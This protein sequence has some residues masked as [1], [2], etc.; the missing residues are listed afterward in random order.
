MGSIFGVGQSLGCDSVRVVKTKI[1]HR[2]ENE[3]LMTESLS[4]RTLLSGIGVA[5]F[6]HLRPCIGSHQPRIGATDGEVPVSG[7]AVVSLAPFDRMMTEFVDRHAIPGASLAISRNGAVIYARG[8]GLADKESGRI[9]QPDSLFRIA[10][11]SKPLTAIA[12]L[13]L[14]S[15]KSVPLTTPAFDIL[16]A[17][18]WLSQGSDDRLRRITI[19]DL[20]RHTAGWDRNLSFDPITRPIEAVRTTN[21]KLPASPEDI[22]RYALT[23]PIDFDPGTRFAYSNVGY[24]LLGRLIEKLSAAKY[25]PYVRDNVLRPAGIKKMKLGRSWSGDL[26][27]EEVRYYDSKHRTGRAVN[28]PKLGAQ[29]PLVYGGENF[30]GFEAHGGWIA[31]AIDLI[32]FASAID[33]QHDP[34]LDSRQYEDLISRPE[35]SAGHDA[36]GKPKPAYYGCG[37]NVRPVRR[38]NG[39]NIWHDGLIAGTSALLVRRHDGLNWAVLFNTDRTA[40]GKVLSGL[41]DPLIHQAADAVRDWPEAVES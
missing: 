33:R 12:I 32:K 18:E 31:S 19:R 41:I 27:A 7:T 23:L 40:E 17:N 10:S 29:V 2:T 20:L 39:A 15:R 3:R 14:C 38:G 16:D 24:L 6:A 11:V 13:Q 36:E 26:E 35:G 1:R 9:V 21:R 22:L 25:E 4:R 37:W 30:E 8:F 34:L 28:G 5:A